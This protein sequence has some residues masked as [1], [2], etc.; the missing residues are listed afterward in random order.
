MPI[1]ADNIRALLAEYRP[2]YSLPQGLYLDDEVFQADLQAVWQRE[3]LFAA[4]GVEIPKPGDRITMELGANSIIILRDAQH[5]V[6]AFHNSCRHRGSRICL[7]EHSHGS[8]LVCPYHQWSYGLDGS[9][10]GARQMP[11][12]F[13]KSSHGLVPVHATEVCGLIYVCLAETPPDIETFRQQ[14][15]P[16]VGPHMAGPMKVAAQQTIIEEGNWKLVIENNRECYHCIGNHPELLISLVDFPVPNTPSA[17]AE[18]ETMLARKTGHWERLGLPYRAVNGGRGVRCI[19]LPF[20]EGTVSFTMDG[21]P[22]VKK[23]LEGFTDPDLGSVRMYHAPNNWNHFLADHTVHF[24][25]LPLSA[26]RT[27]VRTTWL[28]HAEAEEGV[29]YDVKRLTEVWEVTNDQDRTLVQNNHLGIAS[30]VYRP[31]P[32]APSEAPLAD[33]CDW[34]TERMTGFW[35]A[36]AGRMPQAA[37]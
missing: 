35:G 13:D 19:R 24:R 22:A 30:D 27:E 25:V 36:P 14:I 32:Y 11:K 12:D 37:E 1:N 26:G 17:A 20:H 28:V 21:G 18:F 31:G 3:W 34:Y 7:T 8:L 9:L 5:Q 6:R 10:R 29:D 33:F 23:L 4:A 15:T 2:G 16:Y